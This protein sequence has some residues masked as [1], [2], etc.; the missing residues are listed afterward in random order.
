MGENTL[1][2]MEHSRERDYSELPLFQRHK[3][4]GSVNFSLFYNGDPD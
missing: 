2:V 3:A 1:L 4:Y